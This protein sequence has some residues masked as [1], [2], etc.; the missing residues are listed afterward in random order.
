MTMKKT[1]LS[2]SL[3]S[4]IAAA[5]TNA[6]VVFTGLGQGGVLD[7][8][9]PS[10]SHT[11]SG[12]QV[13]LTANDGIVN[14]TNSGLGI[15]GSGSGDDTDGLDTT[16]GAEIL[17][18]SFDVDVVV[19]SITLSGSGDND[20]LDASFDGA[21]PIA[22]GT[23]GLHSFGTTLLAGQFLTLTATEPNAPTANNGISIDQF[24][25]TAVPEPT[26]TALL[27]L[28]GFSTL[29]RRKR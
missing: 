25:V 1:I 28:A 14:A 13:T 15:N 23:S 24:V 3:F 11:I 12:I 21:P 26:S 10:G 8:E 7:F 29:L 18:I 19:D 2:S 6:A 5:S 22:L 17:T 9:A 16:N 4:L 20:A 27:S